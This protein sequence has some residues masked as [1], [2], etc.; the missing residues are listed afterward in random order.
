MCLYLFSVKLKCGSLEL[1]R[2]DH[3]QKQHTNFLTYFLCQHWLV[4]SASYSCFAYCYALLF[5]KLRVNVCVSLLLV[6]HLE[7]IT[8]GL[9]L[10]G[11][12]GGRE[13]VCWAGC[14]VRSSPRCGD[15]L[16]QWCRCLQWRPVGVVYLRIKGFT[17]RKGDQ[18]SVVE[19]KGFGRTLSRITP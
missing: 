6:P 12:A 2:G 5:V 14:A 4:A 18:I 19:D 16:E 15:A 3:T 10:V 1:M 17:M 8:S 11:R 9:G 7:A 13:G